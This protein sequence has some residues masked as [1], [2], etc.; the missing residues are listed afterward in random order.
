MTT[1]THAEARAAIAACEVAGLIEAAGLTEGVAINMASTDY[2]DDRDTS[3]I[4]RGEIWNAAVFEVAPWYQV[5]A[6]SDTQAIIS[7]SIGSVMA[8]PGCRVSDE[9]KSKCMDD[10]RELLGVQLCNWIGA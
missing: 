4:L 2:D 9:D 8:M 7:D 3:D 1:F 6:Y 10:A 5:D